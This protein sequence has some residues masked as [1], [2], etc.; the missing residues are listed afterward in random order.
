MRH[1]LLVATIALSSLVPAQSQS[2]RHFARTPRTPATAPATPSRAAAEASAGTVTP[3]TEPLRRLHSG[4]VWSAWHFSRRP[5]T[6]AMG[7]D[8]GAAEASANR[9]VRRTTFWG[10]KLRHGAR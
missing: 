8:I 3:R 4:R 1:L 9:D 10:R 6:P 7:T 2:G 5:V